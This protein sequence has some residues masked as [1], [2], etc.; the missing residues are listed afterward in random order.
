MCMNVCM[1]M[2]VCIDNW[3]PYITRFRAQYARVTGTN[4]SLPHPNLRFQKPKPKLTQPPAC[5][6]IEETLANS[7]CA[8]GS[9]NQIIVPDNLSKNERKA[10]KAMQHDKSIVIRQ[11]DKGSCVVVMSI[12]QYLREGLAHLSDPS[13]YEKLPLGEYTKALGI[14]LN[15]T[16]KKWL[17][18]KTISYQ[19]YKK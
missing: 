4:P 17:E 13:V 12:E 8:I 1:Y 14:N 3:H 19:L 15:R 9:L 11:A 2:N 5:T 7:R 10:L 18:D 6:Q 16:F